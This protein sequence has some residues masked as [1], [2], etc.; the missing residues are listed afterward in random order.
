MGR[1]IFVSYKY[2]DW[3][4]A[5]VPHISLNGCS[6]V[7]DY[8]TWLERKFT[9]RT[10]NI[11]KGEHDNEDLSDRS[12]DYI[13][14]ELKN[15]IYDS[16]VT[17]VL[18]SPN[19]KEYGKRERDQWIPWE[20]SYSLRETK[21]N[22]YTSHSNAILAVVLPDK[23]GEYNY[24]KNMRLFN[25]LSENIYNNYIPVVVWDDFKYR[26]DTYI[27]KAINAKNSIPNYKIVKTI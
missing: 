10:D 8:V 15:K 3:D 12:D 4:V 27:D 16:S 22:D 11:Y 20:I 17:I 7:R 23:Y 19:M 1:K 24:Y 13:W 5:P 21:R 18:I 6:K 25:I 14:N 9:E 26:C 2:W